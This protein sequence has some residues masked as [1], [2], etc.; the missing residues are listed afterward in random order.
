MLEQVAQR[1]FG[2]RITASVQGHMGWGFEQH[3]LVEDVP[4]HGGGIGLVDL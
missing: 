4:A 1:S 3:D 2:Y